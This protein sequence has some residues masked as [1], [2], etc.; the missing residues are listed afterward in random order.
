MET[1]AEPRSE[2]SSTGVSSCQKQ[3]RT[4]E[5]KRKIVEETLTAGASVARVARA[6]GV[7]D[8]RILAPKGCE[9]GAVDLAGR[10]VITDLRASRTR[11]AES[12]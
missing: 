3:R 10:K 4:T 11:A 5:Q 12:A 1:Q 2:D 9:D 6:H 7:N 8:R